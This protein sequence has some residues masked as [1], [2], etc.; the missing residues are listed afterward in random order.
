[1]IK[2]NR[3]YHNVL[4]YPDCFSWFVLFELQLLNRAVKRHEITGE[5]AIVKARKIIETG[6]Y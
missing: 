2:W 1:M 5:D 6:E 3:F 4:D